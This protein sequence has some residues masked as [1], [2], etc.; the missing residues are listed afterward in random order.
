[1]NALKS[2]FDFS[3]AFGNLHRRSLFQYTAAAIASVPMFRKTASAQLVSQG[4]SDAEMMRDRQHLSRSTGLKDRGVSFDLGRY[5]MIQ[6]ATSADT[7]YINALVPRLRNFRYEVTTPAG[8]RVIDPY[9]VVG[10]PGMHWKMDKIKIDDLQPGLDYILKP[11]LQNKDGSKSYS[12]ERVF[13][14]LDQTRSDLKILFGSCMSEEDY[15]EQ[16]MGPMWSK[17]NDSKPDLMLLVGDLVY[18]DTFNFVDRE[19]ATEMDIWIRYTEAMRTLPFY[20]ARR[21]TPVLAGWDD[22]DAGTNNSHRE[23]LNI[24]FAQKVFQKFFL[25][26]SI[27][28]VYDQSAEG[29]YWSYRN[30]TLDLVLV[31]DRSFKQPPLQY[32]N[33]ANAEEEFSLLGESQSRWLKS[34][35]LSSGRPLFLM[36][37]IQ[38]INGAEAKFIE[39][40]EQNKKNF[41][42]LVSDLKQSK[43]LVVF[44]SGDLHIS[45]IQSFGSDLLGYPLFEVTSSSIHSYT[46]SKIWDNKKRLVGTNEYNFMILEPAVRSNDSFVM[47][48]TCLG[49]QDKPFFQKRLTISR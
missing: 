17:I 14:T 49:M 23:S 37:G 41:E 39:A 5:P 8:K 29:I 40:F 30:S 47:Q 15:F 12:D 34:E 28:G 18:V 25:G 16:A 4:F 38:F 21:L 35:L 26:Q 33:N 3:K 27:Q 22:H 42:R 48:A 6:A 13:Q 46:S 36:C 31:D 43:R 10:F 20:R 2:K 45:E 44:G 1:M 11:F 24:K 9:E 19:K 7:T 32:Q